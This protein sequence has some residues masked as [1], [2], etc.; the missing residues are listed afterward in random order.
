MQWLSDSAVSNKIRKQP[1]RGMNFQAGEYRV[2]RSACDRRSN[3]AVPVYPPKLRMW[4]GGGG[5]GERK[6]KSRTQDA[7]DAKSKQRPGRKISEASIVAALVQRSLKFE[8]C[9]IPNSN[10]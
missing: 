9:A 8:S 1:Y 6:E 3:D 7:Q 10:Q 4:G 5:G 2:R